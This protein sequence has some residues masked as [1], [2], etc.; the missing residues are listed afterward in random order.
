[1]Y[2][3]HLLT[4]TE[5]VTVGLQ[6]KATVYQPPIGPQGTCVLLCSIQNP[7]KFALPASCQCVSARSWACI[8]WKP[9]R[10]NFSISNEAVASCVLIWSSVWVDV[11]VGVVEGAGS[12]LG[13]LG[14]TM[15]VTASDMMSSVLQI[16][17][18]SQKENTRHGKWGLRLQARL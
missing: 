17:S 9:H 13:A 10:R 6:H 3:F 11:R 15:S 7:F 16:S 1:M 18:Q 2:I 4:Y 5:W 12:G 8:I 14:V